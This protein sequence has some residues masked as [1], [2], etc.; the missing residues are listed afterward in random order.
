ML[1]QVRE[2]DGI[3]LSL[4]ALFIASL[5][6]F[7]VLREHAVYRMSTDLALLREEV[8]VMKADAAAHAKVDRKE[9][10]D[11]Y[12]TL[13][14]NIDA[15]DKNAPA[16]KRRPSAIEAWSVNRDKELRGRI[17]ALERRV[18]VLVGK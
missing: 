13:Y 3:V 18:Y 9:F 16:L 15:I 4:L 2:R 7:I 6:L 11:I 5:V 8:N 17:A 14:E 1:Q 12:R 10:D